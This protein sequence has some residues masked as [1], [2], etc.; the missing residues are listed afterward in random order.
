MVRMLYVAEMVQI[1]TVK[2]NSV[3]FFPNPNALV[4]VSKD[5]QAIKLCFNKIFHFLTGSAG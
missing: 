2:V 5:M 4:A 1:N 3:I